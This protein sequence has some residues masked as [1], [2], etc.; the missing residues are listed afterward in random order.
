MRIERIQTKQGHPVPK[1]AHNPKGPFPPELYKPTEVITDYIPF[2]VDI[3]VGATAQNDFQEPKIFKCRFC[4]QFVYEH[5][6]PDHICEGNEDG[7]DA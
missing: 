4:Q 7:E 5:K 2:D 1:S 6:I 3:P